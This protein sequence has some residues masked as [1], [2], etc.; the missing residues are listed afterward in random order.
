[1]EES[2]NIPIIYNM[3]KAH[4]VYNGYAGI[5]VT[6]TLRQAASHG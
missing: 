5:S 6:E 4:I 2:N 3:L 1:M